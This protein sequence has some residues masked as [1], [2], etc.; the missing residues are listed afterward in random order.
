MTRLVAAPAAPI[1]SQR[2]RRHESC[3]LYYNLKVLE[4]EQKP[5]ANFDGKEVINLSSNNYLGLTTH[6]KLRRAGHRRH[7]KVRRRL[8]RRPHH[9]R[10]HADPSAISKSRSP[11]FK[12]VE[13]CVVFQSGFAANAGTVS[14][15]LGQGRPGHFRR[16]Q[17][18]LHHR[19]LPPL[20]RHHQS[21]Q[22]QGRRRLRARAAGN[23]RLA[24]QKAAD[25][26]RR[27]LHGWRHREAPALLRPRRKIRIA[28]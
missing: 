5:V 9:S 4:G 3:N 2:A 19:R 11:R 26:R 25:H 13:A 7:S 28:S 24:R 15:I 17:S 16:T 1:P 8:R 20:A 14:A 21:L 27:F 18:R 10:H 12:N 22:A 23:Q 6:P